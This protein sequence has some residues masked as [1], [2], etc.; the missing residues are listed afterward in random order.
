MS[1]H[2]K[3]ETQALLGERLRYI[4][5]AEME[6][7]NALSK[8]VGELAHGLLRSLEVR[9]GPSRFESQV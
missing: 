9:Q 3:L 4:E 8:Q 6:V 1:E 2:A 7:F 5:P